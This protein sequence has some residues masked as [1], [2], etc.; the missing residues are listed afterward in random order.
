VRNERRTV[1]ESRRGN[2]A[3]S[4]LLDFKWIGTN[5]REGR[6]TV[7]T[8][9]SAAADPARTTRTERLRTREANPRRVPFEGDDAPLRQ[10]VLPAEEDEAEGHALV[11]GGGGGGIPASPDDVTKLRMSRVQVQRCI[12]S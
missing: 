1:G 7:S 12:Y 11:V 5:E 4:L 10:E 2:K 9:S 8:A 3:R 6:E